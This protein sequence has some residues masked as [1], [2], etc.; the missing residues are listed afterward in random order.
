MLTSKHKDLV[1]N[2]TH[3]AAE[4]FLQRVMSKTKYTD[5]DVNFAMGYLQKLL[6]DVVIRSTSKQFVLPGFENFKAVYKQN[7]IVTIIPKGERY[8]C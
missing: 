2:I 8:V 5:H 7:T 1:M 6:R 3:H 4:R